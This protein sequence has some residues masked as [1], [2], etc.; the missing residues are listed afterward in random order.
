[1]NDFIIKAVALN[2]RQFPNLNAS[3][4]KEVIRHGHVNIGVAVAVENGLLTIVSKD[5]DQK[6][7]RYVSPKCARWPAGQSGRC[8]RTTS[9]GRP[10]RSTTWAYD[11]EDFAAIINPPTTSW[12]SALPRKVPVVEGDQ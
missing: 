5:A 8:A 10:S 1:V 12:R 7:I 9:K 11:V 3:L 4:A 2:L 6:P